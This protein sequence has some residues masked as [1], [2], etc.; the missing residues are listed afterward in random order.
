MRDD[1]LLL[2]LERTVTQIVADSD[3]SRPGMRASLDAGGNRLSVESSGGE[4]NDRGLLYNDEEVLTTETL[5]A[6]AQAT[7]NEMSTGPTT[8]ETATMSWAG[9]GSNKSPFEP[10]VKIPAGSEQAMGVV[11][12]LNEGSHGYPC[13]GYS[14]ATAGLVGNDQDSRLLFL[15]NGA[16]DL[17][18]DVFLSWIDKEKM[19][20]TPTA[21]RL[22]I[23]SLPTTAKLVKLLHGTSDVLLAETTD[24]Y[25][26][27]VTGN[28]TNPVTW[29]A[30]KITNTDMPPIGWANFVFRWNGKLFMARVHFMDTARQVEL[31]SVPYTNQTS[32]LLTKQTLSG[33]NAN[34][35]Y[36][37]GQVWQMFDA[38]KV[39]AKNEKGVY[40][41]EPN[42]Y[43]SIYMSRSGDAY[44]W[45]V[46]NGKLRV[47]HRNSMRGVNNAT[48]QNVTANIS[49]VIDLATNEVTFDNPER[50]PMEIGIQRVNGQSMDRII[51]GGSGPDWNNQVLRAA[52]FTFTYNT[53]S[54]IFIPTLFQV[55]VS[56]GT[57][58]ET[59]FENIKS[60]NNYWNIRKNMSA[61]GLYGTV[62]HMGFKG[63]KYIGENT[64]AMEN[65]DNT[66]VKLRWDPSGSYSPTALGY[67]PT[68]DR[69]MFDAATFT[70]LSRMV[71]SFDGES[72]YTDGISLTEDYLSGP[73][74]YENGALTTNVSITTGAFDAAKAAM[75]AQVSDIPAGDIVE[76]R[77]TLNVSRL[78]DAAQV[79]VLMVLYNT[80][81]PD[82]VF[83]VKQYHAMF[84]PSAKAGQITSVEIHSVFWGYVSHPKAY[85]I[86]KG[87]G[88]VR[89]K[90]TTSAA[91]KLKDGNMVMCQMN[92]LVDVPNASPAVQGCFIYNPKTREVYERYTFASTQS[93]GVGFFGTKE[94]G[95]GVT[96]RQ[97]SGE[98]VFLSLWGFTRAEIVANR[99]APEL[100][101]DYVLAMTRSDAGS[102]VVVSQFAV[103]AVRDKIVSLIPPAR[104]VQGMDL[105]Q[106]RTITKAQIAGTSKIPNQRDITY[107]VQQQHRNSLAP[108]ALKTHTHAPGDFILEQA[109]VDAYGASVLGNLTGADATAFRVDAVKDLTDSVTALQA[110]PT[111]LV[112]LDNSIAVDYEV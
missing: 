4:Y 45:V 5:K 24:G 13:A 104:K 25:Y 39:N 106:D 53:V 62:V 14:Y 73:S 89:E 80:R 2:H 34:G 90:F 94:L 50:Y 42:S 15:R 85:R 81:N 78:K 66:F 3:A 27:I 30:V 99:N 19:T 101:K 108:A 103:T 12:I 46:E 58:I 111:Q 35:T 55:I 8:Q 28:S 60:G 40:F 102:N 92:P 51:G 44:D 100:T 57:G 77:L 95:W 64:V 110:R 70:K 91:F 61:S 31:W 82:G 10:I 76:T 43:D 97:D 68:N 54:N 96:K 9:I 75:L 72:C 56:A 65:G 38:L 84:T 26:F 32:V 41:F 36:K 105:T 7:M 49:Y 22:T 16:D 18:Q 23:P 109:T 29:K 48:T 33:N 74:R 69:S 87:A 112:K 11:K 6:Q 98:G 63:L 86:N 83:A 79:A 67:G 88:G 17:E 52:G 93:G 37:T 59:E 107:P 71:W 1:D 20:Y 21:D 47:C